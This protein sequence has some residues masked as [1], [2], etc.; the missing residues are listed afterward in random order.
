MHGSWRDIPLA[1]ADLVAG[2]AVALAGRTAA[3]SPRRPSAGCQFCA[4]RTDRTRSHIDIDV[5]DHVQVP[6]VRPY[7]CMTGVGKGLARTS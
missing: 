1:R 7:A 3:L 4:R 5:L 2:L 6:A